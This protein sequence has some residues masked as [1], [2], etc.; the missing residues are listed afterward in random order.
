LLAASGLTKIDRHSAPV[1]SELVLNESIRRGS[2]GVIIAD[3][4]VLQNKESNNSVLLTNQE[5]TLLNSPDAYGRNARM[6]T[7]VTFIDFLETLQLIGHKP[8]ATITSW[9]AGLI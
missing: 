8:T 4:K 2:A 5:N 6:E 7:I 1:V 3:E 9:K